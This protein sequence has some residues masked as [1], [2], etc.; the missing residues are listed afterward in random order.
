M[1][2]RRIVDELGLEVRCA[3]RN[4]DQ[5]VNGAYISDLLSDVIANAHQG[6]VWITLQLHENTV[7][8]AAMKGLAGIIII[9][10]RVPEEK[11]TER[12]AQENIPIMLSNLSA[13]GLAG[14]LHRLGIGGKR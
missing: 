4:L 12:A 9:N 7:A 2:L 11:T 5:E 10:G 14:E 13:F 8:V 3:P 6:D 1:K